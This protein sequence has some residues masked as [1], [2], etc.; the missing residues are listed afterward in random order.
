MAKAELADYGQREHLGV[1]DTDADISHVRFRAKTGEYVGRVLAGITIETYGGKPASYS[2]LPFR[3]LALNEQRE[4]L[5]NDVGD[6]LIAERA[7][8]G[9]WHKDGLVVWG[10]Q[11]TVQNAAA[12][13]TRATRCRIR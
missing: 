7:P 12:T 4:V 3:S 10:L 13:T 8:R 2:L 5:V 1:I 9:R 11:P 6:Y